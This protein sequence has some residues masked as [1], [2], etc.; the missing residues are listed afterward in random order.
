MPRRILFILTLA[1]T[2]VTACGGPPVAPALTDPKDILVHAVTSLQTAKTVHVKATLAGKIDTGVLT[3]KPSGARV[4]L[5]GSTL[6]GDLDIAN[7]EAKLSASVPSLLGLSA[8][9]VADA[10]TVYLKT[11]LTG[12]QFQKL[13]PA[14]IPGGLALPSPGLTASP[15]PS[16]V[17]DMIARLKT[18]LD[19]LPAPIKLADDRIGDQD[20]YHVQEKLA[21][22][23]VPQ[24]G[25][26][27][28]SLTGT[29][30]VDVWTR[31]SDYRPARLVLAVDSGEQGTATITIDLTV[32]DAA[33]TVDPPPPDQVSA[34]PFTIPSL[35][36][37]P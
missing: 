35:P 18:A 33:V 14:S 22:T 23:D 28:G 16:A 25:G 7:R 12:P 17:A 1:A 15:D 9:L 29:L 6:E 5:A 2:I 24:A 36:F 11:S 3:G 31:K 20:T 8:D 4:D 32:Y 26:V 19:T 10:G 27:L 13:D 30:T 34:Q 21:S 37:G